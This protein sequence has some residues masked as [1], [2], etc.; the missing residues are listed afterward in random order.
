M[1]LHFTDNRG[2]L[3]FPIK[4]NGIFQQCTVSCNKKNVFRGIHINNFE[5]LVTCVQGKI[6]DIIIN[7]DKNA[8]DY[9]IPKYYTLDSSSELFQILVPPNYGHAFLSLEE[10]SILLYHL[11]G[12]FD[13][14][15]T[16]HITYLDPFINI[17]LPIDNKDLIIS[18]KDMMLNFIKPID[19]I[20]FGSTGFLG[21]N[22]ID[23]LK[24]TN[25]NF[26]ISNLRLNEIEKIKTLLSTYS[27]KYVIN[28]AGLCGTPNIFWCDSN[29]IETIETNITYQ[30]TLAQIC[31]ELNI[32]LTIF[33]S[34]GIF[35]NDKNY[36]E[37]DIGNNFSNFYGE[38]KI[39]LE[40]IVKNYNNILYL[41]IN[42]PISDK[43]SNKNL[44]TKL[45]NYKTIDSCE[46][47]ITYIENL[48]PILLKMIENN[49]IGFCNFTNPGQINLTEII[50]IY[51]SVSNNQINIQINEEFNINKTKRS[52]AR[53]YSDM[54]E[55][56]NPLNIFDA[57][58]N[59]INN[60]IPQIK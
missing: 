25:K 14:S 49:E 22:I 54:L 6:L 48:F 58:T 56:Y 4:N 3:F 32:H 15:Y 39:Y 52:C 10:N 26:I 12:E 7:F 50:K 17:T 13:E 27:P 23:I 47:S 45:L 42:Y 57:I 41:R 9:L 36:N 8:E 16:T 28:C 37:D 34:A 30:L 20:V 59:C 43:P 11:A 1:N 60:Y 35:N 2:K 51:N 5:K 31:K 44:L 19:Y 29:R 24:I 33:G 53:L 18:K 40:N 21:S 38:C 46:I 55:K